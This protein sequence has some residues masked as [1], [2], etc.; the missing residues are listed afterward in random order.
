MP[1]TRLVCAAA[2]AAAALLLVGLVAAQTRPP[3]AEVCDAPPV[4]KSSAPIHYTANPV[5]ASSVREQP[6]EK[7]IDELVA[8]LERIKSQKSEL[9]KAEKET[10]AM[11][12][13]KLRQQ[14]QR[15]EKLG[16]AEEPQH[17]P[18]PTTSYAVPIGQATAPAG[19]VPVVP[20]M[21]R[22]DIPGPVAN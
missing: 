21:P 18:V 5:P 20:P 15:L 14:R 12:K 13:E 8:T 9:D 1:R 22:S 19:L 7:G 16:I 3:V 11:L 4:M 10:A 6:R 17:A 2:G